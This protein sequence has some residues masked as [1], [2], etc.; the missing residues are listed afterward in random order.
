MM[1]IQV[2]RIIE[3][4]GF[5]PHSVYVQCLLQTETPEAE[6]Q[7]GHTSQLTTCTT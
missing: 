7:I 5:I 6:Q 2:K 1:H 4:H 3:G